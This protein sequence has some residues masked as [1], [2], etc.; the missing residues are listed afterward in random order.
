MINFAFSCRKPGKKIIPANLMPWI[1]IG[2]VAVTSMIAAIRFYNRV[3]KCNIN[4]KGV[5]STIFYIHSGSGF[6]EVS[7]ALRET[8]LI[9]DQKSFEW[10]SERKNYVSR[11]R[12]GRYRIKDKMTNL[13][14]VNLLRSGMQEP[15]LLKIQNVRTK[16]ELAGRI[17]RR[18]E[19]DSA[20]L[21]RL[22][23]DPVFLERF[24][25]TPTTLFKLFIPNTYEVYWNT[26]PSQLFSRMNKEFNAFWNEKRKNQAALE[27]LSIEQV[28]TLA[29]IVEKETARDD[30]KP[31]IAG[32]YLNRLKKH[33][34]LQ[35]DPTVIFALN[36]YSIR[37]VLNSHTRT[38]SP[39]NT[40]L[41]P[42]LPPGP[43]CLPSISSIDAVLQPVKHSY[44]Y[45][46]A[47]EDF[48]G[49]HSFASDLTTHNRNARK[50]QQAIDKLKIR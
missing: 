24:G 23:N 11:V 5:P 3:F 45:F 20:N 28:V 48:S 22:F 38:A 31:M 42:G 2:M 14:L 35:A 21:V 6:K 27:G 30:E 33:M 18:L 37:R 13:E 17:G 44:L 8:G 15:V 32:V 7:L 39:Y 49:Y 26:S 12:P 9:I 29:S 41:H 36:D 4:L 47:R 25:L 40:Y 34:P 43:I 10:L 50:Y 19:A 16:E 1:L 46:C